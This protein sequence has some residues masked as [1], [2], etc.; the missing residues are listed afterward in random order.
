[1]QTAPVGSFKPNDF[2]LYDMHGIGRGPGMK[3]TTVRPPMAQH[4]CKAAMTVAV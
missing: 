2:G 1:M 3:T 4:G